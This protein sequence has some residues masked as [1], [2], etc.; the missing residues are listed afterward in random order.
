[1]TRRKTPEPEAVP[2]RIDTIRESLAQRRRE[3][4]Q[5]GEGCPIW[6][7]DM[8]YLLA[9]V[10]ELEAPKVTK[11]VLEDCYTCESTGY[12]FGTPHDVYYGGPSKEGQ[13]AALAAAEAERALRQA[14]FPNLM[15]SVM[16]L[17]AHLREKAR[18]DQDVGYN[19]GLDL[20]LGGG[21]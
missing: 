20:G 10:S 18:C 3:R 21:F 12:D 1:M 9:R 19:R 14:Q 11:I 15:F 5:A 16:D 13:V 6:W 2:S 8:D 4:A 7:D 17:N